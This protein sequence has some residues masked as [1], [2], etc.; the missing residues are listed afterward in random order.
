MSVLPE[1]VLEAWEDRD[2]PIVLATVDTEGT[3]N[4]IYASCVNVFSNDRLIVADNYFDKTRK[5]LM[6]GCKGAIL[7]R[8]KKGKAYQA[9]GTMEYHT[10]GEIFNFMKT[11]NPQKHPGHAAAALKV[12]EIY[13]GA[14]KVC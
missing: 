1:N 2:G 9:K 13:S 14:E 3:P 7:F 8:S 5:N 11:W 10:K 4:I 12:E 6:A